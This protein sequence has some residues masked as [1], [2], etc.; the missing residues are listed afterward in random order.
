MPRFPVAFGRRKSAAD[1]LENVPAA[2]PSFRVLERAEVVNGKSFDGGARLAA[3]THH[4][5]QTSVSGISIEDNIFADL[6]TNRYV[7]LG[8]YSPYPMLLMPIP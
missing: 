7:I 3:R 1:S 8:S 2:E 5:P 4:L 6:K